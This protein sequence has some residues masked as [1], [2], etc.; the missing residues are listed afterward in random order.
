MGK[1]IIS[2]SHGAL[3]SSTLSFEQGM[4][5]KRKDCMSMVVTIELTMRIQ[6]Q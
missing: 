5:K 1:I 6:L 3:P 4:S 2:I